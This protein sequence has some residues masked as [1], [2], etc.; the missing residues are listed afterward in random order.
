VKIGEVAKRTGV[1]V[2]TLRYYERRGLIR[3]ASRTNAGYRVYSDET[4]ERI[5]SARR[6]QSL[7]L[8]LDEIVDALH[9]HDAGGA[10][11]TSERWRLETV[12]D[13]VDTKLAELTALREIIDTTLQ[14][15]D[16]G[17][18]SLRLPSAAHLSHAGPHE[19]RE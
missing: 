11:C 18:C 19:Y 16:A 13:R 9:A 15:C 12:R 4:V 7:G 14:Q 6:L 5:R 17:T 3:V 8:T 1:T 10:T 2:D